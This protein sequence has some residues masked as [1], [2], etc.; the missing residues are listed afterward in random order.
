M[1]AALEIPLADAIAAKRALQSAHDRIN[2]VS[3]TIFGSRADELDHA[4]RDICVGITALRDCDRSGNDG[5]GLR[6][7]E[8]DSSD[9]KGDRK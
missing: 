9:G 4:M 7:I 5:S 8:R 6:K 2:R 3:K 1:V